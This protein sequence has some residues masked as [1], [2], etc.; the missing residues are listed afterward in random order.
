MAG[1]VRLT[2]EAAKRF[3]SSTLRVERSRVGDAPEGPG[4]TRALH[5]PKIN[6][7]V[8]VPIPTGSMGSPSNTGRAQAQRYDPVANTMTPDTSDEFSNF[9]VINNMKIANS[10][11]VGVSI[12]CAWIDGAWFFDGGEC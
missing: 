12:R 9:T 2:Y 7:T 3:V 4:P 10:I 11:G 6:A 5:P 8:T 1:T